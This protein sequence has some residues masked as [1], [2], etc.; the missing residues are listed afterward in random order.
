MPRY[1]RAFWTSMSTG[2]RA[3]PTQK[4]EVALSEEW[5]E[6]RWGTGTSLSGKTEEELEKKVISRQERQSNQERMKGRY[7]LERG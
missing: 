4:P 5:T 2:H 1:Q 3:V 6:V 7:R